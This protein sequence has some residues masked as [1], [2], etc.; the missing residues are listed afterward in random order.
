MKFLTPEQ[1]RQFD[2]EGWLLV[3]G[4]L[5]PARDLA[6]VI[7]EYAGVLDRLAE[8]L[9]AEG[10]LG[11]PHRD[12]PFA[13][14]LIEICVETQAT[15]G[16]HFDIALP[17]QQVRPDTPFHAG[18]AV[19]RLLTAP[20]LLDLVEDI[21]GPEVYSNPVQHVRIKLPQRA[22][23][24]AEKG[25]S[26]VNTVPWHQDN[27]VVLPEADETEMLTVWL[28]L[29]DATV[30]NGCLQLIPRSHLAGLLTHC[31][32]DGVRIP[33]ALL[34]GEPQPV[35]V[36]AGS[37]LLM[38]RR[39]VHSSLENRSEGVRWS[40]DLRYQ[41]IGQPTGRPWFPSFVVRSRREPES[42]VHDWR[43]WADLWRAT[44][45]RLASTPPEGKFNRWTG[46]EAVCEV[47]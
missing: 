41:P 38:Q 6:P 25:N 23:L 27:G 39:T 28:P 18:P 33:D 3:E 35:P 5:D 42:E 45:T 4:V 13:E 30:E 47:A 34:P 2:D 7:D 31:R 15:Y 36:R 19:F 32:S 16:Q 21:V 37:V 24:F 17:Q 20:R 46:Q 44:R 14:R 1:R 9:C 12:L 43:V 29:H 22:A 40:F 8:T 26:L 11:S 10:K